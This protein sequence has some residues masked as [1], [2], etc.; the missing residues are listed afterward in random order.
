MRREEERMR[1][2]LKRLSKLEVGAAMPLRAL[3][4]AQA[5][6]SMSKT[7]KNALSSFKTALS[8]G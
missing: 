7:A 2:A 4:V 8:F 5:K 1:A 3:I 6:P